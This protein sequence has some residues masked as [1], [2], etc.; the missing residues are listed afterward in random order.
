MKTALILRSNYPLIKP[1]IDLLYPP[2]CLCCRRLMTKEVALMFDK[3]KVD[4]LYRDTGVS[5]HYR[6]L[7]SML[8]TSLLCNLC[9]LSLNNLIKFHN[10]LKNCDQCGRSLISENSGIKL[11][12]RCQ[13]LS[14]YPSL[15]IRSLFTYRGVARLLT[16]KMKYEEKVEIAN[17][18]FLVII[19]RLKELFSEDP[20]YTH[21]T[22]PDTPYWNFITFVPSKKTNYI[23]RGFYSTAYIFHLTRKYLGIPQISLLP[24]EEYSKPRS[25][26]SIQD[27]LKGKVPCYKIEFD[28]KKR[29]PLYNSRIL[30]LDDVITTGLSVCGTISTLEKY[31]PKSIDVLTLCQSRHFNRLYLR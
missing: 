21:C 31:E 6:K 8:Q 4:N 15:R 25:W 11:C 23:R 27:R 10:H 16:R 1:L 20:F 24:E 30:I 18:F 9:T 19:T 12:L 29:Q 13:T 7:L 28:K 3:L 5:S 2:S 26:S 14:P 17:L 22:S